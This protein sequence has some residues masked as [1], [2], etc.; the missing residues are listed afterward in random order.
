MPFNFAVAIL[1][2]CLLCRTC[3][4]SDSDVYIYMR[5]ALLETW[6]YVAGPARS[7]RVGMQCRIGLVGTTLPYADVHF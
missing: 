6:G 3:I 2:R 7:C 1:I 5:P 4:A